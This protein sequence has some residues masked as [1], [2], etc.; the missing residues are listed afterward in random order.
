MQR[1]DSALA[2]GLGHGKAHFCPQVNSQVI[3]FAH[4]AIDVTCLA[5]LIS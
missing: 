3:L 1:I 4:D 2:A 5:C